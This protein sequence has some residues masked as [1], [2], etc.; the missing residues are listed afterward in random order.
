[1]HLNFP[2]PEICKYWEGEDS[3]ARLEFALF[4]NIALKIGI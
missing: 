3:N 4:I 1:M 2:N